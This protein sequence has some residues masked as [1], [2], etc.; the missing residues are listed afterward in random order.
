MMYEYD[1]RLPGY[2]L[3]SMNAP[4]GHQG[5][6]LCSKSQFV[7]VQ[8]CENRRGAHGGG[9]AVRQAGRQSGWLVDHRPHC[10]NLSWQLQCQCVGMC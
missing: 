7:I 9:R 8:Q 6:S 5:T 3:L 4:E 1:H 2:S 10:E